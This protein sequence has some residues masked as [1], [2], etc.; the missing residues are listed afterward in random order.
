MDVVVPQLFLFVEANGSSISSL[1]VKTLLAAF[2]RLSAHPVC[3]A[4]L[5]C[6]TM[7]NHVGELQPS[8][9]LSPRLFPLTQPYQKCMVCSQSERP[10]IQILP[11]VFDCLHYCQDLLPGGAVVLLGGRESFAVIG[12]NHLSSTLD[13]LLG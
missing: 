3:I 13:V 1:D 5:L 10:P 12:D 9:H 4:M 11:E 2:L 6:S 8:S 7:L